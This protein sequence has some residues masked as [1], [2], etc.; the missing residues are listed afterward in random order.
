MRRVMDFLDS[1]CACLL[2]AGIAIGGC[3]AFVLMMLFP[4]VLNPFSWVAA[5]IAYFIYRAAV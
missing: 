3:V 4:V 2:L 1:V 5:A